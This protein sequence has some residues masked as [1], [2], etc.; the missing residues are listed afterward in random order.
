[1]PTPVSL[2]VSQR[3]QVE[4][5]VDSNDVDMDTGTGTGIVG[6][7]LDPIYLRQEEEESTQD[8]RMELDLYQRQQGTGFKPSGDFAARVRDDS[9]DLPPVIQI[10]SQP[11]I[12][13]MLEADTQKSHADNNA[14]DPSMDDI[15]SVC[16]Y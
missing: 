13:A 10:D 14:A 6:Q 4:L 5:A 3:A 2:P 16:T 7:P 8:L 12:E 1:M 9:T 15:P 11:V